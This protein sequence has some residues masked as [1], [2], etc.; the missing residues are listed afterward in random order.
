MK[1]PNCNREAADDAV[2]CANCHFVISKWRS[3]QSARPAAAPEPKAPSGE[4]SG[5]QPW[6]LAL[7]GLVLV[8][9]VFFV[10][11]GSGDA[12]SGEGGSLGPGY[13]AFSGVVIDLYRLEPVKRAQFTLRPKGAARSDG[14]GRFYVKVKS[15]IPYRLQIE[16]ADFKPTWLEGAWRDATFEQRVRA[17]R[18]LEKA[19]TEDDPSTKPLECR[20]Q[21]ERSL[22]VGLVPKAVSPE[23]K[24]DI[25]AVP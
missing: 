1:C 2:E 7:A 9:G 12:D 4:D 21:E 13:C 16:H 6:I 3:A 17:S 8:V 15:G 20:S 23:E 11:H 14:A 19:G 25:D 5:L 10:L 18:I 24:K 22:T